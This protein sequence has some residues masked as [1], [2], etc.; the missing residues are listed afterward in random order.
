MHWAWSTLV[1]LILRARASQGP[2]HRDISLLSF[3]SLGII[4]MLRVPYY[5]SASAKTADV[6]GVP[7]YTRP[8]NAQT[9]L[10]TLRDDPLIPTWINKSSTS[11]QLVPSI[12]T[13]TD[14][15]PNVRYAV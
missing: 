2:S 11:L 4:F 3:P 13:W 1:R 14:D 6:S 9:M 10:E 15:S 7:S 5:K 8:S 12:S